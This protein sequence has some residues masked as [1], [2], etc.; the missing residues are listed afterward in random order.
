MKAPRRPVLLV[1]LDGFGINPSK[2]N[3]AIALA[4]TPNFD[5]Y[6]A[7]FPHTAIQA[8]GPAVG[9]PDGQM[10]NSEVG[11]LTM[12]SGNIVR[13]DLVLISDAIA[14]RSFHA[15]PVLLDACRTARAQQRPLLAPRRPQPIEPRSGARISGFGSVFRPDP[16]SA[17]SAQAGFGGRADKDLH[18]A[19]RPTRTERRPTYEETRQPSRIA[20]VAGIQPRYMPPGAAYLPPGFGGYRPYW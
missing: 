16:R 17:P 3:N 1:I 8:S 5:R 19:F 10:G 12:G 13:Q 9:L 20:P 14:E 18:A 15:N 6:F 2:S 4:Q 11:H 7:G